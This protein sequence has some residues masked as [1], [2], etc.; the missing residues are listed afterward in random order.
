MTV[1]EWLETRTPPAPAALAERLRLAAGPALARDAADASQ[2]L[3]A[4]AEERLGSF[5]A[6][7][8]GRRGDALE[9]LAIDALVTYAFEAA[10]DGPLADLDAGAEAAVARIAALAARAAAS[11]EGGGG[12]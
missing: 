5:L 7:D 4:A 2:V 1:G 6:A 8:A 10:A 11:L 12:A 3:L 9:L